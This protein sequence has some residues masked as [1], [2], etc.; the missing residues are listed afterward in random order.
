MPCSKY[1]AA[2]WL[3]QAADQYTLQIIIISL[4][5]KLQKLLDLDYFPVGKTRGTGPGVAAES[6]ARTKF[7]VLNF[8]WRKLVPL[9]SDRLLVLVLLHSSYQLESPGV[10]PHCD[11]VNSNNVLIAKDFQPPPGLI[12]PPLQTLP[13]R[14]S[15]TPVEELCLTTIKGTTPAQRS[16]CCCVAPTYVRPTTCEHLSS[17]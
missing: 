14:S 12:A 5:F 3:T 10:M 9:A 15:Y 17:S 2:V 11:F 7:L 1:P 4:A 6:K 13:F 16:P 8:K